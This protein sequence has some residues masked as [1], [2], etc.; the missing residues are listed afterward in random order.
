MHSRATGA[1]MANVLIVDDNADIRMLV[2][3]MVQLA[4]HEVREASD[5]RK[6]LEVVAEHPPDLMLLDVEMPVLTGP[7][8]AFEVFLRNFG[9]EK[10]PIILLSGIVGLGEVAEKVGTPYF[11]GKPYS[12]DALLLLINRALDEQI[13]PRPQMEI[14]DGAR[15]KPA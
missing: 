4:G 7:E 3:N 6:G 10:I 11:L 8:M 13:A 9:L 5:G 2:A 14:R 12:P 15:N 1:D